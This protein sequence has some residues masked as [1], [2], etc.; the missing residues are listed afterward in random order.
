[1]GAVKYMPWLF[2]RIGDHLM[3]STPSEPIGAKTLITGDSIEI[4]WP[5][6]AKFKGTWIGRRDRLPHAEEIDQGQSRAVPLW[7]R[8]VGNSNKNRED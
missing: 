8:V 4:T 6:G 5:D 1:M 3:V 2:T 7:R